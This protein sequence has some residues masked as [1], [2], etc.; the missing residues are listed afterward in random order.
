MYLIEPIYRSKPAIPD[1]VLDKITNKAI[2]R[3]KRLAK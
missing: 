3:S 2:N 1:I